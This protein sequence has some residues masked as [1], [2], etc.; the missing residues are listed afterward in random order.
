MEY[1]YSVIDCKLIQTGLIGI[2]I[3]VF[4]FCLESVLGQ[5]NPDVFLARGDG[6]EIKVADVNQ[7]VADEL[8][9]GRIQK[10]DAEKLE[11]IKQQG[12]EGLLEKKLLALEAARLGIKA[13][14]EK[15]SDVKMESFYARYPTQ[16]AKDEFFGRTGTTEKE[17]RERHVE[18]LTRTEVERES[19]FIKP[20][21]LTSTGRKSFSGR[22]PDH[23]GGMVM[24][25]RVVVSSERNTDIE[26]EKL[27][28]RAEE[29]LRLWK[30][31]KWNPRSKPGKDGPEI[32]H[33]FSIF[34]QRKPPENIKVPAANLKPGEYSEVID[35]DDGFSILHS[36]SISEIL[37]RE[38]AVK[39][40]AEEQYVEQMQKWDSYIDSLKARYHVQY[41]KK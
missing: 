12:L 8:E 17:L 41:N 32:D 6:F 26:K 24:I 34:P 30:S 10:A 18:L 39:S 33:K 1:V 5:E 31:A 22:I 36:Y 11:E 15:S 14:V 16:R 23:Q 28:A 20:K 2:V 29:I 21:P 9:K 27:K 35:T 7:A 13:E 3:P 40:K 38:Q 25:E 37:A 19:G 4:F